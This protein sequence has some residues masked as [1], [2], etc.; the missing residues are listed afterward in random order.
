VEWLREAE[1]DSVN[2]A[3]ICGLPLQPPERFRT[4]LEL[5]RELRASGSRLV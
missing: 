3:L 1:L 4:T 5:V 2:V